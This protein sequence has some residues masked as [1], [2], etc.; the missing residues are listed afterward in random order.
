MGGI[1]LLNNEG[2]RKAGGFQNNNGLYNNKKRHKNNKARLHPRALELGP[3]K[4][5]GWR[6][7]KTRQTVANLAKEMSRKLC[8]VTYLGER[9]FC[10]KVSW[11]QARIMATFR[12]YEMQ[13]SHCQ[14]PSCKNEEQK[15]CTCVSGYGYLTVSLNFQ[16]NLSVLWACELCC[17]WS[18]MCIY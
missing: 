2:F 3:L 10:T 16:F 18:F 11:L 1:F 14:A 17:V 7:K 9:W 8:G 4:M 12:M 13:I 6:W 15:T 5:L